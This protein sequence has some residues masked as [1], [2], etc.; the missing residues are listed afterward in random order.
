MPAQAR[1]TL[2]VGIAATAGVLVTWQQKNTADRRSE[3]WR[4]TAWAFERSLGDNNVEAELG[5][6]VLGT[7][8]ESRLAT[9]ATL[10]SC[11]SSPST[12]LSGSTTT[13]EEDEGMT[14]QGTPKPEPKRLLSVRRAAAETAV[15]ASLK[16]GLPVDE[17]VRKLAESR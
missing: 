1:V 15:K 13:S 3:W 8:V 7:L 16:T 11:R 5:W 12:W 4:R 10:R 17:R 14:Q 9:R 2:V 6:K